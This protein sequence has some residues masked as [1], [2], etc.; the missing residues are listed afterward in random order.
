[1]Q[2]VEAAIAAA[3]NAPSWYEV[4]G[5]GYA[6]RPY[7]D[8]EY[9][10]A[11]N[12]E[13]TAEADTSLVACILDQVDVY[14][15]GQGWTARVE[16]ART[17]VLDASNTAKFSK[18]V[19][20]WLTDG[21]T[22]SGV[23]AAGDIA[24]WVCARLPRSLLMAASVSGQQQPI[25]DRQVYHR[26]QQ[27]R[28]MGCVKLGDT[29]VLLLQQ[30]AAGCTLSDTLLC[31]ADPAVVL[32]TREQSGAGK[33][34]VGNEPAAAGSGLAAGFVAQLN[35]ALHGGSVVS[36]HA[37]SKRGTDHPSIYVHTTTTHCAHRQHARNRAVIEVDCRA[38]TW[39]ILCRD[40]CKPGQ[41]HSANGP[42]VEEPSAPGWLQQHWAQWG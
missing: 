32:N 30:P 25:V 23:A 37:H 10:R 15:M 21:A 14:C 39:R 22:V 19:I 42:L 41:W 31:V 1:M 35:A 4:V 40:G 7:F 6:V 8:L 18:H 33:G 27:M 34:V 5:S 20:V 11:A 2:Q 12:P 28:L 3:P 26:H 29:R 13:R 38:H 24:T 17:V 16:R 36:V 9:C